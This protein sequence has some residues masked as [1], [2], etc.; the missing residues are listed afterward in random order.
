MAHFASASLSLRQKIVAI[1]VLYV[2]GIGAMALISYED[3][4]T[5]EDKLEFMRLGH[6]IANT[7]LEVRRYE[8][9]Y[10]LYGL[11][12]D[13]EEDR[14]YLETSFQT[15]AVLTAEVR[16]LKVSPQ[17]DALDGL[18]RDYQ[19]ALD[20]LAAAG[21][22]QDARDGEAA[23][24]LREIGKGLA[25]A[26]DGVVDFERNRIRDLLRLLGIQ[27]LGAVAV[28]AALGVALPLLMFRK[29][30]KPLGVIR[31]ATLDIARGRFKEIP[32][33]NTS[34][35]IEQVMAAINRMVAEIE[36]R[37]D[38]LVQ[39]KKLSSIGTLTAG[40]AHQLNNPLNN[41]STSSQIA[42][43]ELETA[44]PAFLKKLLGNIH[45][46]TLRARDI[47]QGLLE[48]SR[49]REFSLRL[50]SLAELARRTV[51]L[52]SSQAS[53][54]VRL[55]LDVP[56]DLSVPAD[57][58]RLQEA[59]LNL[60]INAIQAVGGQGEVRLAAR[61][62]PD[63]DEAVITVSDTG[64]GIPADIRGRIFDPF[65]TT[66]EEG[67]GTGLGLSIVY[68]I[69]EKHAGSVT[70]ESEPGQGAAFHIR[71]PLTERT[72]PKMDATP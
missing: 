68:G 25:D 64:P 11:P 7:I 72:G 56:E 30:F 36:R 17:L 59:L 10:L 55:A 57:A 51:R 5:M 44:D 23:L 29:I 71:L 27:L 2:L 61:R 60:L 33:A 43:E 47:V 49:V 40:V 21:G 3:L 45:Q 12:E 53:S 8:K 50:V 28:A 41:I 48:F 37:Q 69:V 39:S 26:A 46:E 22:G 42:L 32:V 67:K 65:Y 24:R 31:A 54:G 9:N 66:K 70:V 13:L 18:L 15:L 4:R 16:D 19:K 52:V 62:D 63:A 58:S 38:Q 6:V 35:E 1:L 20:D 34:D 14:R